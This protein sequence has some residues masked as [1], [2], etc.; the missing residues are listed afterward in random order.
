MRRNNGGMEISTYVHIILAVTCESRVCT[1]PIFQNSVLRTVRHISRAR[2]NTRYNTAH[3]PQYTEQTSCSLADTKQ[4]SPKTDTTH[5]QL[6]KF[7][8]ISRSARRVL[9]V[10]PACTDRQN[11]RIPIHS[12]VERSEKNTVSSN[13]NIHSPV[14]AQLPP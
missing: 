9:Y 5:M 12:P 4:A 3:W 1:I 2:Y 14:N 13:I 10:H 6:S 11:T 7:A 8:P